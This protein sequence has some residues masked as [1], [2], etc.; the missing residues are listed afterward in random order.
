MPC[1][2]STLGQRCITVC[3]ISLLGHEVLTLQWR[4]SVSSYVVVLPG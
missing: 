4:T 1:L 3:F 2:L